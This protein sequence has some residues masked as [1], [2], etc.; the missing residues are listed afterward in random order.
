MPHIGPTG[1]RKPFPTPEITPRDVIPQ[2]EVAGPPAKYRGAV[3]DFRHL[4]PG[5]LVALDC[6]AAVA[7][8]GLYLVLS[9]V[10]WLAAALALSRG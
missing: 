6:L 7:L 8:A 9:G 4:R 5:E 1:D 2:D 3:A 10:P